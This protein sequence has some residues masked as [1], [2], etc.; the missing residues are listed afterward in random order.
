MNPLQKLAAIGCGKEILQST[1][2]RQEISAVLHN[3]N[4]MYKYVKSNQKSAI[5][6]QDKPFIE[7]L[8]QQAIKQL[9]ELK[10][11]EFLVNKYAELYKEQFCK[12]KHKIEKLITT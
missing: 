2:E 8:E 11:I 5:E 6:L 10:R 4:L 12:T 7:Y 3:T 1:I 9:N